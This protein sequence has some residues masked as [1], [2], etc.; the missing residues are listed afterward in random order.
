M[1]ENED[2]TTVVLPS[3]L[4]LKAV[5]P[6]HQTFLSARGTPL[7]INAAEVTRLG[8]LGLQLLLSTRATWANDG[9]PFSVSAP[10]DDF[11]AA[12]SLF[13]ARDLT[14]ADVKE[15]HS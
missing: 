6:L 7:D 4:D 5:G 13:G 15:L 11:N 1:A 3:V 10:S 12:L 8:G 2:V 9:L 14:A